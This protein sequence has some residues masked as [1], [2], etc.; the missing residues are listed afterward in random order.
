MIL[1]FGKTGQVSTALGE[2]QGTEC[3]GRDRADLT[4]PAACAAIIKELSPSAVINA[5][6]YTAVDKAEEEE[7]LATV[8]NGEAPGAMAQA[9][10]ELEIPFVHISTDYVFDGSGMHP[11]MPDHDTNP[12]GAYGRSKLAG[13]EAV[14]A[15]GGKY[16]VLRTSW[17]FSET[18]SNFLKTMLRIGIERETVRV[19]DDQI[20]G[21]TYAPDIAEACLKIARKLQKDGDKAGTYHFSGFDDV[22]WAQFANQIFKEAGL[23]CKVDRIETPEY[24]TP[25]VRPL[26]S[27]LDCTSTYEAFGISRPTWLS[28]L[29]TILAGLRG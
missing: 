22:S 17:V 23:K 21:P 5:A 28:G 16:A 8:I 6:A 7:A 9:A 2:A 29:R 14:R 11:W 12:Q 20:G 3:V 18:G 25:A 24:P 26:N 19:V 13:E 10:A 1:V 27:R 15:A 4:D